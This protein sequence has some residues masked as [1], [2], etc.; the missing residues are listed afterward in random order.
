[1]K[2]PPIDAN[3]TQPIKVISKLA[4]ASRA[5]AA[6]MSAKRAESAD[7]QFKLAN[8]TAT[9]TEHLTDHFRVIGT[10]SEETMKLV[11]Q[12]AERHLN[13]AKSVARAK[14]GSGAEDYFRGRATIFVMPK[15]IRLQRVR[16]DG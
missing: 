5:T 1:M 10:G 8:P 6:E 14:P 13:V 3:Q 9:V 12:I 4:W 7:R 2:A 11:G 16:Q 15:T